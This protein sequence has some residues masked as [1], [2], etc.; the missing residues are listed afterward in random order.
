MEIAYAAGFVLQ[1]VLLALLLGLT[2]VPTFALVGGFAAVGMALVILGTRRWDMALAMLSLGSLGMVA[3]WGADIGFAPLPMN[4]CACCCAKS[5][6]SAIQLPGMWL[7]MLI[8]SNAAMALLPHRS[9]ACDRWPMF[10]GGNV[11]MILG[12]FVGGSVAAGVEWPS[13][14]AS[15]F[16]SY[17]GMTVGMT[18]GMLIGTEAAG[19][20]VTWGRVPASSG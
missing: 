11:G 6:S 14:P 2:V 8:L 20:A 19:R 13:P 7:G 16:A 3:G 17:V 12:M 18:A 15:T 9:G 4:G 5:V 10:T 1:G